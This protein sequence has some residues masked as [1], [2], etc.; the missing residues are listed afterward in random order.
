MQNLQ[1]G[2]L[3]IQLVL[4]VSHPQDSSWVSGRN[5]LGLDSR[6]KQ[7][8]KAAGWEFWMVWN[9]ITLVTFVD[10]LLDDTQHPSILDSLIFCTQCLSTCSF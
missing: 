5:E 1:V 6:K 3:R 8:L 10:Q 2:P 9:G 4:G 7:Q